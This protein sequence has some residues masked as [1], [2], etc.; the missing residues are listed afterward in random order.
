MRL[1]SKNSQFVLLMAQCRETSSV[2][3]LSRQIYGAGLG[4]Q[5]ISK[6]FTFLCSQGKHA[7]LILDLRVTTPEQFRVR[8]TF[9]I[10]QPLTSFQLRAGQVVR[11]R[12]GGHTPAQA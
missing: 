11:V 12:Y 10:R 3:T 5:L 9:D 7:S 6:A 1:L 8:E 2:A 4:G